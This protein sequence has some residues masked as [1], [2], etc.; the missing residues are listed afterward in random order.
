MS[1]VKGVAR[2]VARGSLTGGDLT[3]PG[4]GEWGE[5]GVVTALYIYPI[6]SMAAVRVDSF[7]V[8]ETGPR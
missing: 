1:D 5:A 3:M 6:K 8:H 7:R 4:A 2:G